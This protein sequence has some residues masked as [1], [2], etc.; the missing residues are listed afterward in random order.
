MAL[1]NFF[2]RGKKV[3]PKSHIKE[4][5]FLFV[6]EPFDNVVGE[7]LKWSWSSWWPRGGD[8]RYE[9]DGAEPEEG[10]PC[11]LVMNGKFF[12]IVL[13]GE[14]VQNRSRR[15]LQFSWHTGLIKGQEFLI[16][17]E[18]SNGTRIDHRARYDGSNMIFKT[19]WLLFFRKR[20]DECIVRALDA[21]KQFITHR[22]EESA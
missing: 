22:Q 4:H 19:V 18:R 5:H 21:L 11:R 6:E 13:K 2:K 3:N 12:N 10:T 14:I 20:Y 9:I 8:L 16:V 17:E 15:A 1:F 7:A